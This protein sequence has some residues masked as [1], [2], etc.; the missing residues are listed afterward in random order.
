MA[1]KTVLNY[2]PRES[3]IHKLTG[4]TK[5]AFFLLFTFASMLTYNTWVLLGLFAVSL[6]AFKLSKIKFREVRFMMIFMLVF[7]IKEYLSFHLKISR[8]VLTIL[9]FST[10]GVSKLVRKFESK[11]PAQAAAAPEVTIAP[12]AASND[13]EVAAA[14]VAAVAK[15]K[16]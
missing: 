6:A 14:I 9:V 13:A 8:N 11:R 16:N 4:T 10:L 3:V 15:S 2:L 1:A 12:T 7:V 5:L